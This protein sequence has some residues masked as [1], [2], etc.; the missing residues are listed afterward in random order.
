MLEVQIV[1]SGPMLDDLTGILT[2]HCMTKIMHYTVRKPER[3]KM[4]GK[5]EVTTTSVLVYI[6]NCGV[7]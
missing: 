1:P 6:V 7:S 2:E 3:Y 5:G 4:K